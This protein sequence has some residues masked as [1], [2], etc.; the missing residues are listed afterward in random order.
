MLVCQAV[1]N[2]HKL[3]GLTQQ[4]Q[5]LCS[6]EASNLK[7]GCQQGHALSEGSWGELPQLLVLPAVLGIVGL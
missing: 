5:F 1:T 4:K 2:H 6:L 3:G 7:S